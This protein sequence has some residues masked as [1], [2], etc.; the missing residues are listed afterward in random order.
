VPISLTAIGTAA[1]T[2][3]SG[4]VHITAASG[5]PAGSL[6]LIG[7]ADFNTALGTFSDSGSETY[8]TAGTTGS[9]N[10]WIGALGYAF[11]ATLAT[12]GT[13]TYTPHAGSGGYVVSAFY[14]TGIQTSPNPLDSPTVA[15]GAAISGS[16]TVTM[17]AAPAVASSLVVGLIGDTDQN[18]SITQPGGWSSPPPTL[19]GNSTMAITLAG[20]TIVSSS[21]LTYAPT[22]PAGDGWLALVAA[23]KPAGGGV[24]A[25][26]FRRTRAILAR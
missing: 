24:T 11:N 5:V 8:A 20:A 7:V 1:N 17:G 4:A 22:I 26:P 2:T 16:P 10:S 15:T 14:A 25:R 18:T 3:G 6:I 12:N 13:V 19:I 21:R 23:F 9:S